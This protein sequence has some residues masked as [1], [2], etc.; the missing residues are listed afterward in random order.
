MLGEFEQSRHFCDVWSMV[1]A[2]T[3]LLEA[4]ACRQLASNI[5]NLV[6]DQLIDEIDAFMTG[7]DHEG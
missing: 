7:E 6:T 1:E 2:R 3:C 4:V 5:G